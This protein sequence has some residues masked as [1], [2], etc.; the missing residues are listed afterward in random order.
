MRRN[1][2]NKIGNSGEMDVD[3]VSSDEGADHD[4]D[5]SEMDSDDM[6]EP[7]EIFGSYNFELPQQPDFVG[8]T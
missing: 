2:A 1:A 6:A 4:L 3:E 5:S 7:E 8:F